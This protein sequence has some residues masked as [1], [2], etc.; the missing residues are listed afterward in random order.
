[1]VFPTCTGEGCF[2]NIAYNQ[3]MPLCTTTG[4]L[5]SSGAADKKRRCR[6]STNLCVAD[7]QFSFN[8]SPDASKHVSNASFC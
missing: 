8:L 6:D 7:P 4:G 1:M 3:Q 2:I 5:T